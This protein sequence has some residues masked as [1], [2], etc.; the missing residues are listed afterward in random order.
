[1]GVLETPALT[2]TT[3]GMVGGTPGAPCFGGGVGQD[4]EEEILGMEMLTNLLPGIPEFATV[5]ERGMLE[6]RI[7]LIYRDVGA[8]KRSVAEISER[9][10]G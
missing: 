10:I 6:E 4:G 7:R 2:P 3:G 1:V 9:D 5:E 8:Y